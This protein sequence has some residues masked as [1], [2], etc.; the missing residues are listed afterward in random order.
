MHARLTILCEC[1]WASY[2]DCFLHGSLVLIVS[3]ILYRF[4]VDH[5]LKG[6]WKANRGLLFTREDRCSD[7]HKAH[8]ELVFSRWF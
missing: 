8:H 4:V 6:I 2:V 3:F 5:S 7:R 1:H